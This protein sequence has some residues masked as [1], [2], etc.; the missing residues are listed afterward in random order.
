MTAP[1]STAFRYRRLASIAAGGLATALALSVAVR[2]WAQT[3]PDSSPAGECVPG[4]IVDFCSDVP[5][6]RGFLLDKGVYTTIEAPGAS[7]TIPF[8]INNRGQIVGVSF[9]GVRC[10]GFLLSH[11]TFTTPAT[12][13]GI[14]ATSFPVDIDDRGR[15]VGVYQ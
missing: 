7:T 12:P 13:P 3:S 5:A 2:A 15:I 1:R 9:D 6:A 4:R 8:G 11:G 14:F 10:R